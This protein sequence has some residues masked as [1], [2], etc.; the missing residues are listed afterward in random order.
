M[1][2]IIH[3]ILDHQ[4]SYRL[5]SS[6][7]NI[8]LS[9]NHRRSSPLLNS[10]MIILPFPNNQPIS[11]HQTFIPSEIPHFTS[12]IPPFTTP[13]TQYFHCQEANHDPPY[14]FIHPINLFLSPLHSM[15]SYHTT[16]ILLSLDNT[17]SES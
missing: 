15:I 1:L 9:P 6:S 7:I 14:F 12:P 13:S 3:R 11:L 16:L 4:Q 17:L 8:L 5:L 10:A 2:R